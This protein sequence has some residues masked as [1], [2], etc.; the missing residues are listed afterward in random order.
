[1]KKILFCAGLLALAASCAENELDSISGQ[2]GA[3]RG[4]SFEGT[5][6][7]TPSTRGDL[8]YDEVSGLHNFFWYAEKDQISIWSTNTTA[9]GSN[10]GNNT[11]VWEPANSAKYKATQSKAKGVFTAINDDNILNFQWDA[12]AKDWTD[13]A[14]EQ[15][16]SQ[17][18]A[19]YPSIV[20][21]AADKTDGKFEFSGLPELA[22]QT[23]T[24]LD[25]K[26]VTE[27]IMMISITKAVKENSY[28]AVGEK[29]DLSFNRPFTAVVFRTKGIDKE[30]AA[31]FGKLKS[32][33]LDAKGYDKDGNG[34]VDAG[35]IAGSYLD[36][37][38][39]AHYLYDSKNPEKSKLVKADGDDIA[40]MSTDVTGAAQSITLSLGGGSGL[41]FM[42]GNLAY[43][44]IN[45]INRKVFVDAK[46]KET[47][48]MKFSFE[49]IDLP[50]TI[51]TDVNWPS[52]MNNKFIGGEGMTL[53]INSFP[54]LVTN[55][56][57][58]RTLIVNT[59]TFSQI[60]NAVGDKVK[61]NDGAEQEYALTEFT[62]I[63]SKVELTTEE[64]A[65]LKG[66]TSVK[67]IQ[68]AENTTIP[69]ETF[70][71]LTALV[72]INL[73][74]VTTVAKGAFD[75]ATNLTTVIMP[76][77]KF[78]DE[79]INPEIL[80]KAS[81]VTLDMSGVDQMSAAFPAKG[82]SLSG[83]DKLETITVKDGLLV[84]ASSFNGCAELTDVKGTI[85]FREDGAAAF[86]GCVKLAEIN[87]TNTDIP[88]DAFSG[89]VVLEKVLKDGKQVLPTSVGTQAF[90]G[91]VVM[92]ELNLSLA[93]AIGEQA[94]KGCAALY[95][96]QDPAEGNKKIMYVGATTIP[97]G[98][99]EDCK[100][101]EY[102]HFMEATSFAD[103]ILKGCT[104]GSALKEIKF[105]KAFTLDSSVSYTAATFGNNTGVVKLFINPNQSVK[106]FNNNTLILKNIN[107]D[108]LSITKE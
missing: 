80:K 65:K 30:C 108:F 26:D 37:G 63:I 85:T 10:V 41:D 39:D 86:K 50:K 96:V 107:I 44:A 84:G 3:S 2:N 68:L 69:A 14:N 38:T 6:V 66:F 1:M 16:K 76:S 99:F 46:V 45:K 105:K 15:Y 20:K 55:Q 8:A 98:A 62:K 24:T 35:D 79:T 12:E 94:F 100:A 73:P 104:G 59:G 18:I 4:I 97:T 5:L 13:P 40:D 72:E 67:S 32:I 33:Q 70:E 64:L 103:D 29:I 42:D 22:D 83:Y 82:L 106:T 51:E 93:T 91:C 27:K 89:C 77:Y 56:T 57:N 61:W 34:T 17:F 21:L 75:A 7:E 54:Y 19:T 101:L 49:K 48:A 31:I 36:Y 92:K 58:D 11:T 71:N 90:M 95:G 102:V 47:M 23:Q 81:L 9:N 74:K 28:D 88:A 87:V 60:F 52:T 78:A 25:G 43:M 53:D